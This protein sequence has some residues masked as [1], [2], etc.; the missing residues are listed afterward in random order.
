[1]ISTSSRNLST[2][3][4]S[5]SLR[6]ASLNLAAYVEEVTRSL[7]R[8]YFVNQRE[9]AQKLLEDTGAL[10]TFSA[11]IDTA[12]ALGLI[13]D[14]ERRNLH[15]V[16]KI[17][18]EFAHNFNFDLSFETP[19][20]RGLCLALEVPESTTL[21]P[22]ISSTNLQGRFAIAASLLMMGLIYRGQQAQHRVVPAALTAQEIEA[23]V[24]GTGGLEGG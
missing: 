23:A 17:R 20:I 4:K 18:N 22:G 7:L 24:A 11:R 15:L 10:S 9:L 14:S 13:A 16:R 6:G 3:S 8:Q 2:A 1:M 19:E 21:L 12:Y 5:F